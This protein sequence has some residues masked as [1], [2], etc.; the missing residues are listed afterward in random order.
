MEGV[1]IEPASRCSSGGPLVIL[2]HVA[3]TSVPFTNPA[4]E[5]VAEH[6]EIAKEMKLALQKCGQHLKRYL[7]RRNRM[8]RESERATCFIAT[9][10]RSPRTCRPSPVPS[11]KIWCLRLLQPRRSY[12]GGGH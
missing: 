3:S 5:A 6:E 1:W 11:R 7:S 12:R 8:R 10:V 9:S 4:K 2:L